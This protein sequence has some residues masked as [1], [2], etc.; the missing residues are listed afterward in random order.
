MIYINRSVTECIDKAASTPAT[1][2]RLEASP[3]VCD[4]KADGR[5]LIL[6]LSAI[7]VRVCG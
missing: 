4:L 6:F 3:G 1:C 5:T 7:T 2:S